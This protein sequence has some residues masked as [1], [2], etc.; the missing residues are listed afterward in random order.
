MKYIDFKDWGSANR[1]AVKEIGARSRDPFTVKKRIVSQS[2]YN[3]RNL[4]IFEF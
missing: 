1:E 4:S 3:Q 2:G